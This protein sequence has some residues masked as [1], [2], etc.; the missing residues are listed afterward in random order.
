MKTSGLRIRPVR[1][2]TPGRITAR[3]E[4]WV[5][6]LLLERA[7]EIRCGDSW[8]STRHAVEQIR[9]I[10]YRAG[11]TAIAQTTR[12]SRAAEKILVSAGAARP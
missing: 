3:V 10:R 12:P 6:A 7:A 9:A 1:H 8:R 2:W 4:L 5:L 11:S